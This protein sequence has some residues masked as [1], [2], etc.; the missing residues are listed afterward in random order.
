MSKC[1]ECNSDYQPAHG[2][3]RKF[4]SKYCRSKNQQRAWKIRSPIAWARS[5]RSD[6]LKS[7]FGL[8]LAVYDQ[9]VRDQNGQCK[10]CFKTPSRALDVDHDH[11][12]G[13]IRGLLCNQCNQGIGLLKEDLAIIQAAYNYLGGIA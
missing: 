5:K 12:T 2:N 9:M 8:T 6:N 3:Q 13:R 1:I 11:K 7:R 4:C 10:I